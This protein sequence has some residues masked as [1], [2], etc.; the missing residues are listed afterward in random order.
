MEGKQAAE[1]AK[2]LAEERRK[3][4]ALLSKLTIEHN[5][6]TKR[7]ELQEMGS[8]NRNGQGKRRT[9]RA[10]VEKDSAPETVSQFWM[11]LL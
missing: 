1:M 9:T 6:T 11:Q 7:E 4:N 3:K 5:L 8:E 10:A 2:R